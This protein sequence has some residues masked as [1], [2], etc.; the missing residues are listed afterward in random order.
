MSNKNPF[1]YFDKI[2]CINLDSR[3]DRWELAQSEFD[4]VGISERVERVTAITTDEVPYDPRPRKN[5]NASDLLGQ[6]ACASSHNKCTKLAI[7]YNARNYLV[8]EDDFYFKN[9][10]ENYLNSCINE[11]PSDWRLF[12]FGYNDWSQRKP[13]EFYSENLNKMYG[14]GLAHAYAINGNIF[15]HL[16]TEFEKRVIKSETRRKRWWKRNE[17][18]LGNATKYQYGVKNIFAFQRDGFSDVASVNKDHTSQ[19]KK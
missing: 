18:F 7:Q 2:F 12:S 6:F 16:N 17:Y 5:R 1:D 15:N 11:L 4:K 19:T 13:N 10:N 9:Y 8:F 3:P 14:F